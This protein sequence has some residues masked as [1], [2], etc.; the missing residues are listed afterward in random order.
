MGD[1]VKQRAKDAART[2]EASPAFQWLARAGYVA[3]GLVH[4]VIGIIVLVVAF[5]G[6]G[7]SDQAGAFKAV[8]AAP[9]GFA[10]LWT[11]ARCLWALGAWHAVDGFLARGETK[12]KWSR[13]I[14]AWG[15]SV[16]Y[17]ALGVVAAA[18]AL[19]AR[20]DGDEA[21]EGASRGVLALPGGPVLLGLIGAAIAVSG[22]VFAVLGLRRSFRT[23]MS[24][25]RGAV[26]R[27]VTVLGVVGFVAKGV[28][29]AIVGVLLVIAAVRVDPDTAS[30]LDGAVDALLA[31][32]FGPVLAAVVGLGLVAYGVFCGF[33]ARYA[34]FDA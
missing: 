9:L 10:A 14:S 2:A 33:R 29:L 24:I 11:V 34:R 25:P 21:A 26:G 28:A 12:R 31:L 30:G 7:E 27:V 23:K 5:G 6:Q 19:G 22:V 32:P 8:A 1:D 13:R 16:V 20:P 4:V 18:V 3:S 15:Q 17:I